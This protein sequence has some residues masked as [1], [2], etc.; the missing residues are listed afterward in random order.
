MPSFPLPR[1]YFA[2]F[3]LWFAVCFWNIKLIASRSD[4]FTY[5]L[6]A[7]RHSLQYLWASFDGQ[8]LDYYPILKASD[9]I[10]PPDGEIT[11][12]VPQSPEI[13]HSYLREKARYYLYPKNYGNNSVL[14]EYILVYMVDDFGV[15]DG[16]EIHTSF[17]ESKYLLKRKK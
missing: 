2:F 17:G 4:Y 15:P 9:E 7:D 12:I 6:T 14:K 11:V 16:Y 5:A 13:R 3:W 1:I 10:V 8:L